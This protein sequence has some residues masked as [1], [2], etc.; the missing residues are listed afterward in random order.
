MEAIWA[1]VTQ[2]V[3]WAKLGGSGLWNTV[4]QLELEHQR[5]PEHGP[6][7]KCSVRPRNTSEP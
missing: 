2:G 3:D 7:S 1:S 4:Q 6:H 5:Y